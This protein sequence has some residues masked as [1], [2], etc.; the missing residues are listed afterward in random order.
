MTLKPNDYLSEFK[1][2]SI[3]NMSQAFRLPVTP[4]ENLY[5]RNVIAS[6]NL[7]PVD[8]LNKII[9]N[10]D[11]IKAEKDFDSVEYGFDDMYLFKAFST[12][13]YIMTHNEK[14]ND[15]VVR[16]L[17]RVFLNEKEIKIDSECRIN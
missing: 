6:K 16:D 5:R 4:E 2:V 10:K 7:Y 14:N 17:G 11:V 9:V 8:R 1:T 13:A 3:S 15:D 12:F